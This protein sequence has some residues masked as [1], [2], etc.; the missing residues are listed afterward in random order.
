M[1]RY[2][3]QYRG[4]QPGQ[5]PQSKPPPGTR[6]FCEQLLAAPATRGDVG[7][8]TVF[9]S[10]AWLFKFRNVVAALRSFVDGLPAGSPQQFFWY[11][12]FCVDEHASQTMP[13]HWWSSTF[14]D[15]IAKIGHTVMM[16]VCVP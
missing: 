10:H 7:T 11:D 5:P 4:S 8:P 15:A 9:L 2:S 14:R 1:P 12:T 13:Q 3:H 6:S 16:S